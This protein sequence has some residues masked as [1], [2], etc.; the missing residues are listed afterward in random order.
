M[1][2]HAAL[3]IIISLIAVAVVVLILWDLFRHQP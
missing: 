3:E 2:A 1:T